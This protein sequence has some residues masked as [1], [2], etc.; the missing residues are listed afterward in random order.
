MWDGRAVASPLLVLALVL[1]GCGGGDA[2]VAT[3]EPGDD[4]VTEE[5]DDVTEET[6][7]GVEWE[8]PLGE[9]L[10]WVDVDFNE[11]DE[12]AEMAAMEFRVEELAATCMREQGFE[13]IPVD[14]TQEMFFEEEYF[15]EGL[16]W[17]S[18][19][20][21]RTYGF[22]ITTQRFSQDQVGPDLVGH[23]FPMFEDEGEEGG[24]VD[25]NED[26]VESLTEGEREAYFE[27]L[28]GTQVD[29]P[30]WAWESEER[31][32]T[33]EEIDAMN[34]WWEEN[35]VPG[36]MEKSS[37]EVFEVDDEVHQKFDEEFGD[38]LSEAYERLEASPEVVAYRAEVAACVNERG[39]EYASSDEP[40]MYFE[41]KLD[42]AGLGWSDPLEGID[43][44][45][46]TDE[47]F[48]AAYRE[49][50]T[51]TLPP[52]QLAALAELQR[53]EIDMAVAIHECGGGWQNEQEILDPLRIEMERQF[54]EDNRDRLAPYEGI[55]GDG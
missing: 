31:E 44:T 22:G 55:F 4:D 17:G 41:Q 15:G 6:D 16:E 42:D 14:R 43:T 5:T 21:V 23:D 25:P 34:E 12:R 8:S 28:H 50:E 53:E 36:C 27:A 33:R 30:A 54:L 10:G 19:E 37:R 38:L 39:F 11:E 7:D 2:D 51:R 46:W 29:A 48:E 13:Y 3:D 47:Q 9:F 26:Y 40:F 32:P 20:F 49:Y 52:D 1:G 35:H 18:D 24:F 45:G